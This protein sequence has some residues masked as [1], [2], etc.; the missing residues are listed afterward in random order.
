VPKRWHRLIRASFF[1]QKAAAGELA[2][3]KESTFWGPEFDGHRERLKSQRR[4]IGMRSN[5]AR[6]LTASRTTHGK[7]IGWA[8]IGET[9]ME[10][11][12]LPSAGL[13]EAQ[14]EMMQYLIREHEKL[15]RT[16]TEEETV[17]L[18]RRLRFEIS[19]PKSIQWCQTC[20]SLLT[21]LQRTTDVRWMASKKLRHL[22]SKI[23]LL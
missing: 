1:N 16:L 22:R 12:H 18:L 13:D 10:E 23:A 5:L 8:Q 14:A 3:R 7:F 17:T 11:S 9:K 20:L 19:E 2:S 6:R 4:S 15:G 21:L